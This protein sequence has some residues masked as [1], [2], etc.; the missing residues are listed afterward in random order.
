MFTPSKLLRRL[1]SEGG[2]SAI[3]T[4]YLM[5]YVYLLRSIEYPSKTYV[6]YAINIKERFADHNYGESI[7]SAKYK[8]WQLEAYFAFRE[9]SKAIEF[10]K[11]LKSGSG[12]SFSK[13]HF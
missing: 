13:K 7:Y 11:Y 1:V 9:K 2:R 5:F 4:G 3:T 8:P 6:G 12:R 10:E